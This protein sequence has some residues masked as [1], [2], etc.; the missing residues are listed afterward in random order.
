LE[1]VGFQKKKIGKQ[2]KEYQKYLSSY[3]N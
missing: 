3:K 1:K 2:F